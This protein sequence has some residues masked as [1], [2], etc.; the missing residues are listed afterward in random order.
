MR[1]TWLCS[2][3]RCRASTSSCSVVNCFSI[4]LFAASACRRI[5][6]SSSRVSSIACSA[7]AALSASSLLECAA[8]RARIRLW[9]SSLFSSAVA[10]NSLRSSAICSSLCCDCIII[11]VSC[12]SRIKDVCVGSLSGVKN[13]GDAE[14][15]RPVNRPRLSRGIGKEYALPSCLAQRKDSGS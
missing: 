2:T 3:W 15:A 4:P 1:S 7:L 9:R 10:A 14:R 12:N 11:A 6:R 8:A 5:D 13:A